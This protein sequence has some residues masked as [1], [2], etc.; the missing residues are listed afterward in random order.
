MSILIQDEITTKLN[1]LYQE[2]SESDL[3][4]D[5]QDTIAIEDKRQYEYQIEVRKQGC[6][7]AYHI[8][9]AADALSAIDKIELMYGGPVL[10]TEGS[11]E[12]K[13]GTRH[14]I[15]VANNWHGYTFQAKKLLAL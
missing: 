11:I 3:S 10:F 2:L 12:D 14:H 9:K 8:V 6:Y 4:F 7:V 5:N 15:L 1:T 13:D